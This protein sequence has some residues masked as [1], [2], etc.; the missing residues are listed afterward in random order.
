MKKQF[1]NKHPNVA[2]HGDVNV[3]TDRAS[4]CFRI[5][6]RSPKKS[7]AGVPSVQS[8]RSSCQ[9][10]AVF[11]HVLRFFGLASCCRVTTSSF[12][13]SKFF[14]ASSAFLSPAAMSPLFVF[15]SNV[16]HHLQRTLQW[17]RIKVNPVWLSATRKDR[18]SCFHTLSV[19]TQPY[20]PRSNQMRTPRRSLARSLLQC[21]RLRHPEPLRHLWSSACLAHSEAQISQATPHRYHPIGSML[22]VHVTLL[23]KPIEGFLHAH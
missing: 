18:A 20:S 15:P 22:V 14:A 6:D 21:C 23:V 1:A 12:S 16:C 17:H 5:G 11:P 4:T 8:S 3:A 2:G 13:S 7:G 9:R 19:C 10:R